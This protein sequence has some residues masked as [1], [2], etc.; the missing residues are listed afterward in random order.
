MKTFFVLKLLVMVITNK[1]TCIILQQSIM[2]AEWTIYF[3]FDILLI[4][5]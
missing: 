5:Y 1:F 4:Y 2:Y 3:H